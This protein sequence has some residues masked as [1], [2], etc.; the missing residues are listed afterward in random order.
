MIFFNASLNT[1]FNTLKKHSLILK[2]VT[3][4]VVTNLIMSSVFFSMLGYASESPREI[5]TIDILKI[6]EDYS[7]LA[8][9]NIHESG[10]AWRKS[11]VCIGDC[12]LV[13]VQ[14]WNEK[15]RRRTRGRCDRFS[16]FRDHKHRNDEKN[17]RD[18]NLSNNSTP[19]AAKSTAI[20]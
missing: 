8:V 7:A 1:F 18:Y 2:I 4:S 15:E 10:N 16:G 3:I 11:V 17:T 12:V 20:E 5:V 13:T 6:M 19:V 14:A 9:K